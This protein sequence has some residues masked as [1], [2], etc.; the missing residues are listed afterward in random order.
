MLSEPHRATWLG[1]DGFLARS[2]ARPIN[3]F[4]HV[5]AAGGIL[6]LAATVVAL[7]W[8]NSPWSGSYETVWHTH[9][10]LG[11]G[12]HVLQEDLRHWVNDGLMAVFFFVIALEI[13]NEVVSGDLQT[14]SRAAVPIAGALGG[15]VAPALVY[16][17]INLGGD[18]AQGWGIPMATDVAF[19]LGALALL[20][21]RVPSAL[22]VLL[23][24]LAIVDDV[25]AILVIALFYSSGLALGWL[26]AAALGLG[27]IA[28]LTRV[29]VRYLPVYVGLAGVV[30][31]ATFESGVHATIAGVALGLLTPARALLGEAEADRV[32]DELS[33]DTSVTVAEV[34]SASFRLKESVPVTDRLLGALHPWTSYL[35]I[36]LFALANAG[37]VLSADR[38]GDALSSRVTLGVAIG[39]VAGK[40][41][42]VAGGI[43]L[44]VRTGLGTLPTNLRRI[45]VAGLA[46]AAGVGFTV[47]IFVAGLAFPDET[48]VDD[49]K[50]GILLASAVAALAAIVVLGI[51]SRQA[52]ADERADAR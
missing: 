36:P 31:F 48:V 32:A 27:A 7:L 6:L 42:G 34:R 44:A 19:A 41:I 47:S 16:L 1:G 45:H 28:V 50:I 33:S 20:G 12:Q 13:K 18:G 11:L 52:G 3:R 5:E 9:L 2:V 49:A 29:R 40:A 38:V 51:G 37:V 39:L 46:L 10:S 4:L 30:W 8:A 35:I 43:W 26:A 23:L 25:G 15:M 21:R 24:A 22:K 14:A 17:A